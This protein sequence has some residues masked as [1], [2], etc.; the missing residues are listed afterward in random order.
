L[1]KQAGPKAAFE[2]ISLGATLG[3]DDVMRLGLANRAV[4]PEAVLPTAIEIASAW[5]KS[6]PAQIAATK[7]MFYRMTELS[8]EAGLALGK[9]VSAAMRARAA[10]AK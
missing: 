3:A 10:A 2:L 6:D 1:L 5:A 8:F 7:N 9:D 4:A